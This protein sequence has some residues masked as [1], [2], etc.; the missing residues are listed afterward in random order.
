M[1]PEFNWLRKLAAGDLGVNN[2]DSFRIRFVEGKDD[3][4]KEVL[5]T[6]EGLIDEDL[7]KGTET[8]RFK[9]KSFE[10]VLPEHDYAG[11]EGQ[12]KH[13]ARLLEYFGN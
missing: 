3:H 1:S 2:L 9:C 4:W 5:A 6:L 12:C 11:N 8:F 13:M 7:P 10:L